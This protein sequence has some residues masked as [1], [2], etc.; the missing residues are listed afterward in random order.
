MIIDTKKIESLLNDKTITYGRITE[1][2]GISKG[3]IYSYRSGTSEIGGMTINTADKLQKLY[4]RIQNEGESK[5]DL[6][7]KGIKKA[8]GEFNNNPNAVR[9]Y[10]DPN[11]K[12]VWANIYASLN[13][14]DEYHD[15]SIVEIMNK[16]NAPFGNDAS[17]SMRELQKLCENAV[18]QRA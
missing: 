10:F 17:T 12:E 5:M 16:Q 4:D 14:R 2:T 13:E 3:Q 9:I 6:K 7:I 1:E 8:V 15:K 11:E 18:K